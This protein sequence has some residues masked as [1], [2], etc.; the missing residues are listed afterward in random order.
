MDKKR[1]RRFGDRKDGYRLRDIDSIHAIMPYVLPNRTDNETVTNFSV[2]FENA[3]EYIAQKNATLGEGEYRYTLFHFVLAV[4]S[5]TILFRPALNYFIKGRRMY[6]RN[7]ISFSFVVKKQFE[8]NSY[9]SL[10]K[11]VVDTES[12]VSI[13]DQVYESVKKQ[14]YSTR[15]E[16]KIDKST[17][18]MDIVKKLPRFVI[19]SFVGFVNWFDYHGWLPTSFTKDDPYFSSVFLSNLGS[20]QMSATYHHLTN[21]GTNSF[22]ALIGELKKHPV[23]NDDGT[24]ELRRMLSFG[25]TIDERI[26]DGV[27][28]SKS[29]KYFK[30]LIAN[31]HLLDLPVFE[32]IDVNLKLSK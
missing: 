11:F 24:F 20:I 16:H 12:N 3:L 31:P 10:A 26:A 23:F 5:K 22:F 9:E 17:Q 7:E 14:V 29:I 27:Y 21:Y 2:D 4:L 28:F 6:E 13:I 8:D 32:P 18:K 1:K 19:K 25:L 30:H 15:R